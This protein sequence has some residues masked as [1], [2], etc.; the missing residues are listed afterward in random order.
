MQ[1]FRCLTFIL[2]W[3]VR[4]SLMIFIFV[5]SNIAIIGI[6]GFYWK[7]PENNIVSFL[8]LNHHIKSLTIVLPKFHCVYF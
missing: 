8:T 3:M 4:H 7:H 1:G 5:T 2:E 6:Q